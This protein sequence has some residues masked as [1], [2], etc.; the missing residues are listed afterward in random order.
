MTENLSEQNIRKEKINTLKEKLDEQIVEKIN[1]LLSKLS[2]VKLTVEDREAKAFVT[3]LHNLYILRD[4]LGWD[5]TFNHVIDVAP[6][7][8]KVIYQLDID[9]IDWMLSEENLL[10]RVLGSLEK[11]G[12]CAEIVLCDKF[13]QYE[14]CTVLEKTLWRN[15]K[16][17]E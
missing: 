15:K 13:F 12:E 17:G 6:E 16:E 14:V 3:R 5:D 11:S 7:H 8:D 2:T 4:Y 9:T 1:R 10:N